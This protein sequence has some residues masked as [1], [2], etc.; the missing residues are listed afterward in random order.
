VS[1]V[2]AILQART[3]STRLPGKVLLP[4]LG[5]PMLA[6]QIE[7]VRQA[8]SLD[9]LI[10]ATSSQSSDDIL[11]AECARLGVPC[12]RGSLPDVLDRFRQAVEST[13][14]TVV[15]R[16]TG[17]CPLICPDVIDAVVAC[18]E[19]EGFDY[20]CSV[21][22]PDGLDVEAMT[23][24][25]L[26]RAWEEAKLPSERAHVTPYIRNHSE[27]FRTGSY[28][29]PVD[30]SA[31]R[32]TVDEPR[33]FALVTAIYERLYPSHPRFRMSDV[34]RLLDSEPAL[35]QI[36]SGIAPNEGYQKSL[37]EDRLVQGAGK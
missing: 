16:L 22:F 21:N 1:Q 23:R 14:A 25:T 24:D 20:A 26:L 31:D 33:D 15:V 32:W 29:S 35:R 12:I 5:E 9:D 18:R 4:L 19:Q 10:V 11:Q 8:H 17:D 30:Y 34:L 36:N 37:E 7:R 28:V 27:L 6:R 3:S 2:V 13:Q